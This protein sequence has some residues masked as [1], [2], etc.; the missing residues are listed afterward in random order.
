MVL[1]YPTL[2]RHA[3]STISKTRQAVR[4]ILAERAPL[5][6]FPVIQTCPSPSCS[7]AEMPTGLDIDKS[8]D[9]NGSMSAYAQHL[10]I[11]SGQSDW[12]SRIEDERDTASWGRFAS[13]IKSALGRNGEFHDVRVCTKQSPVAI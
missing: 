8:R 2:I 7:C 4:Q 9:L 1:L 11:S 13:D 5:T 10:I 6:P 3:E 12:T